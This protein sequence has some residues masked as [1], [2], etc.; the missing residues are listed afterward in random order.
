M[1]KTKL[2]K[3]KKKNT[4]LLNKKMFITILTLF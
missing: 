3:K 2:V 1:N 4:Y